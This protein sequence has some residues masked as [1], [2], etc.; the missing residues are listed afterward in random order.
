LPGF[1]RDVDVLLIASSADAGPSSFLEAGACGIPS[2]STRVGFPAEVIK[3]GENGLFVNR[4][5]EEM[6]RALIYLYD[7]REHL[8]RMS[9]QIRLDIDINWGYQ[10]RSRYWDLMFEA[11]LAC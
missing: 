1:Y 5:V 3:D 7:H 11:S 4:S 9:E 6:V 8:G 2:I 10:S